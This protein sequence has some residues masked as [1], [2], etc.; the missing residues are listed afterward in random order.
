MAM[1]DAQGEPQFPLLMS[2]I[3]KFV[4]RGTDTM[5]VLGALHP[6]LAEPIARALSCALPCHGATLFGRFSAKM[7]ATEANSTHGIWPAVA[8]GLLWTRAKARAQTLDERQ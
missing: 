4:Q 7:L 6:A 8:S 3:S 5:P 2:D 1:E